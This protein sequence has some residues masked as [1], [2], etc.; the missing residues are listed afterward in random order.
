[1]KVTDHNA[2]RWLVVRHLPG[3]VSRGYEEPQPAGWYVLR[4][5]PCHSNERVC[6]YPYPDEASA[7]QARQAMLKVA[8]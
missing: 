6:R 1:M 7:E 4:V 5:C 8:S 3:L 2:A